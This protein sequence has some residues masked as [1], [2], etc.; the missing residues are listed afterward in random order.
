MVGFSIERAS[1][2]VDGVVQERRFDAPVTA[3]IGETE[4]GKSTLL[5]AVWWAL[6]VEGAKLMSAAAACG[7]LGFTARFG[8]SR[9]RITRST[10][11][12]TQDIV[13]T[14]VTTGV[15]E[16]HPVK[17]TES[18]RSAADVF[19][20]LLGVPRL[21]TG[22]TRV[23]LDLLV[24]WLYARQRGLPND[25]LGGQGKEQRI[26]VGRV[27]L[28]A[29]DETVDALRQE[30]AARTK[31]WRSAHNRVNKIL[32]DRE[33]RELPSVEALQ[34]RAT[35]WTA[36]RQKASD[37]AGQ[38]GAVLSRLH[39]ELAGLQQKVTVA[40]QARQSARAA[41]DERART[42]RLLDRT[43][44]EARG[45]LAGLREAATDP[46]LCPR[47]VQTLDPAGLSPDDCP[48]CRRPDPNRRQRDEQFERRL[49]EAQQAAE[50]AREA[51]HRAAQAADEARARAGDADLVVVEVSAAA[52]AFLQDVIAPQQQAV[53][54]AEAAVRELTARLEQNAEHLRELAELTE[55]RAQL[56]QLEQEKEAAEAAYTAAR[57]DTDLMVKQGTARWSDHLLRRMQACDPE[58]STASVSPDDFS[59]TINGAGFDSRVVAGHGRTR[60][61]I[62][63]L[64]ALRDTAR[65]VPAMPLPQFLIVDGPFTGLGSSHNDQRIQAA[66]LAGLT[67]LAVTEHP[68]GTTGQVVIACTE[69]PPA[70]GPAVR[71]I[72]T[73]LTEGAIPG[74]PPRQATTS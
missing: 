5:E 12:P 61:N 59:V 71:E 53:L 35:Q 41:A 66:L 49:S 39:T 55:L 19:Q 32:R 21:G 38:A 31:K 58:V 30:S 48:V 34:Q 64:L 72:H 57:H 40:E 9:R 4:S 15:A 36:Q 70:P 23:T 62:N 74:L 20:D 25:Y 43:A 52:Q 37:E 14:D 68:S 65:D 3:L 47:C 28:G 73:S 69:L 22:R 67:D 8:N 10:T 60:I 1:F 56:P 6:G 16:P 46:S 26:A 27:L 18:R 29:D 42:A 54:E 33:E 2:D 17:R 7:S 24:P 63:V 50:R 11:D 51:A 13:F 45:R 44:A